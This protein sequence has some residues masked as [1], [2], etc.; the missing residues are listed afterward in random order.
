MALNC[1]SGADVIVRADTA[2]LRRGLERASKFER[3]FG[4]NDRDNLE[5]LMVQIARIYKAI[6]GHVEISQTGPLGKV[7]K[8]LF[9][10]LP[11]T[12]WGPKSPEAFVKRAEEVRRWIKMMDANPPAIKELPEN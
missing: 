12:T 4:W 9:E 10:V 2:R 11:P 3:L 7:L 8:E 1:Y 6:G 5:W